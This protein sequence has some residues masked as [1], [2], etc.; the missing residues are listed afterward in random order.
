M[1]QH[2]HPPYIHLLLD[3]SQQW[4][5]TCTWARSSVRRYQFCMQQHARWRSCMHHGWS[6]H[7]VSQTV[8][9][10][11]RGW[12]VEEAAGW[13]RERARAGGHMN[14]GRQ[15]CM[16]ACAAEVAGLPLG[17]GMQQLVGGVASK[18]SRLLPPMQQHSNATRIIR[19]ERPF[20]MPSARPSFCQPASLIGTDF[21][22]EL[23]CHFSTRPVHHDPASIAKPQ[24]PW[25]L[26]QGKGR[27]GKQA[28]KYSFV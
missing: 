15:E 13:Y 19:Y 27:Q 14:A 21:R 6:S 28:E 11:H 4:E 16:H 24:I 12:I 23:L 3:A 5:H 20:V 2:R 26:R 10:T 7:P 9:H 22:T 8:E 25:P 17:S 18:A 1:H